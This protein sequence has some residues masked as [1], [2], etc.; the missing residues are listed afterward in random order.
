MV[1]LID[2]AHPTTAQQLPETVAPQLSLF[3]DLAA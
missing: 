2:L 1:S 3:G